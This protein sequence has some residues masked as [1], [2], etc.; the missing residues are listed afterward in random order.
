MSVKSFFPSGEARKRIIPSTTFFFPAAALRTSIVFEG[1][2]IAKLSRVFRADSRFTRVKPSANRITSGD[3]EVLA[4]SRAENRLPALITRMT[5]TERDSSSISKPYFRS[6][7]IL[8][9]FSSL[10]SKGGFIFPACSIA[11]RL[12]SQNAAFTDFM[13]A[14]TFGSRPPANSSR[15]TPTP[16]CFFLSAITTVAGAIIIKPIR[17][18]TSTCPSNSLRR[19]ASACSRCTRGSRSR[20]PPIPY[21]SRRECFPRSI[22]RT[23]GR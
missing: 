20:I 5:W 22:A 12:P 7:L 16:W 9:R 3:F 4:G 13:V 17:V 1:L 2:T 15:G 21:A 23:R 19:F 14:I 10:T 8:G 11:L 6:S 18:L